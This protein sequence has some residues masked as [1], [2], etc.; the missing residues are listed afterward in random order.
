MVTYTNRGNK[1]ECSYV[2]QIVLNYLLKAESE[3]DVM[4]SDTQCRWS[5]VVAA[6]FFALFAPSVS[7]LPPVSD[8]NLAQQDPAPLHPRNSFIH[9]LN[10][11]RWLP[12]VQH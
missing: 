9:A 5:A 2:T 7:L 4:T 10:K 12:N 8:L 1:S 6:A 3:K 11:P